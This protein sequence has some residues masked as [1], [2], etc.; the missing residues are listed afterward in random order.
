MSSGEQDERENRAKLE[1][2][3]SAVLRANPERFAFPEPDKP[4][5]SSTTVTCSLAHPNLQALST[6]DCCIKT[7][8]I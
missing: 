7:A 6:N 8:M 5:S 1:A 2:L 4:R 3:R